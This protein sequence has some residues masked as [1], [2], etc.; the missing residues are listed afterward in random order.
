[1]ANRSWTIDGNEVTGTE[2]AI[3]RWDDETFLP[4]D[5]ERYSLIRS[6][7]T[8]EVLTADKFSF[9]SGSSQLQIYNLGS[10]NTGATLI[11]TLTK[12]K[13]KSKIKR[14]NRVNSIL[15]DKS[16]YSSSGVGATTLND[17]LSYGNYPYG[18][19]VQ[20]QNISLK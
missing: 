12:I 16:I 13:P 6:D 4:F 11:A 2:G 14:K 20:D 7:G 3:V 5:T 8:T 19:R 18:T 9:I 10:N 17:G 15:I 1:M